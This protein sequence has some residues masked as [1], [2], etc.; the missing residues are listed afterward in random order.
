[1]QLTR[2]CQPRHASADDDNINNTI[3]MRAAIK[4]SQSAE[5]HS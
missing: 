4:P 3:G 1:V 2:R 5:Y